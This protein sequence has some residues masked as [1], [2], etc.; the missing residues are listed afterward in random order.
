MQFSPHH[1]VCSGETEL[2]LLSLPVDR[3]KPHPSYTRH[4]LS[5]HPAKLSQLIELGELA[6]KHPISVTRDQFIVD[7]YARWD[8]AKT[9]RRAVL[10]CLE[11]DLDEAAALQFLIQA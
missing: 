1:E 9:Q 4:Q 5:V 7:G 3:L 11:H 6:F 10:C 8:L 2:R